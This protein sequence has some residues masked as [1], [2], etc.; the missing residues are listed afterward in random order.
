MTCS[1][2][3]M[4]SEETTEKVCRSSVSINRELKYVMFLSQGQ[5]LEESSIPIYL[6]FTLPYICVVNYLF[7]RRDN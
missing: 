7:R 3:S 5:Q 2:H 4:F 1:M 6:V